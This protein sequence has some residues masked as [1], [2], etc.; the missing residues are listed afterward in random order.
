MKRQ[1]AHRHRYQT[2]KQGGQASTAT[3]C[4]L[5]FFVAT[6]SSRLSSQNHLDNST[7][8][9]SQILL[10]KSMQLAAV[11]RKPIHDGRVSADD[12]ANYLHSLRRLTNITF[13]QQRQSYEIHRSGK[14]SRALVQDA[15]VVTQKWTDRCRPVWDIQPLACNEACCH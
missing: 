13:Q 7:W 9:S 3:P 12:L 10:S 11:T 15:N 2:A 4:C 1:P 5:P 8:G 6:P 14:S